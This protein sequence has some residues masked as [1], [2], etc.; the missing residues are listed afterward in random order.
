[1]KVFFDSIQFLK[2]I[3]ISNSKF[4]TAFFL[5]AKW[6]WHNVFVRKLQLIMFSK[7]ITYI[8][9]SKYMYMI[10]IVWGRK[11]LLSIIFCICCMGLCHIFFIRVQF[12]ISNIVILVLCCHSVKFLFFITTEM[13]LGIGIIHLMCAIKY[14][15]FVD[16]NI[17]V[18]F[19]KSAH[20]ERKFFVAD[21]EP[22][23]WNRCA[24][25]LVPVVDVAGMLDLAKRTVWRSG[26]RWVLSEVSV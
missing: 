8:Y 21:P 20:L 7:I 13:D 24:G 5:L 11:V 17:W 10:C 1:M 19:S 6:V 26:L 2:K 18:L 3:H 16:C 23:I 12:G 4:F 25:Q 9:C 14:I 22:R 15:I